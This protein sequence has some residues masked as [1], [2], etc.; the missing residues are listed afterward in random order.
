MQQS[1]GLMSPRRFT[2]TVLAILLAV[3][4]GTAHAWQMPFRQ[5]PGVEYEDYPLPKDYLEKAEWTF[6]RLMYPAVPG[7]GFRGNPD[8]KHGHANWTIDYPASDRHLSAEIGRL[9][10]ISTRSVEQP[11]D[12]DDDDVFN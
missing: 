6:A 5:Y 2:L 8:W 7:F 9:T 1:D 10:R 11:I 4:A 12:L 3:V